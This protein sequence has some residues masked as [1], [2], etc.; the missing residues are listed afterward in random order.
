MNA[1]DRSDDQTVTAANAAAS[2]RLVLEG[3]DPPVSIADRLREA[4][5]EGAIAAL[6]AVAADDGDMR[7]TLEWRPTSDGR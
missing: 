1:E 4:Y 5:L 7:R 2:L 3:C 6:D